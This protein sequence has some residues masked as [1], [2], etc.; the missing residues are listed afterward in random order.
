MSVRGM[1]IYREHNKFT[2]FHALIILQEVRDL[3]MAGVSPGVTVGRT[4]GG[5]LEPGLLMLPAGPQRVGDSPEPAHSKQKPSKHLPL[6]LFPW[7][8]LRATGEGGKV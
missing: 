2:S 5:V 6:E 4:R 1:S 7:R 3:E 8:Y